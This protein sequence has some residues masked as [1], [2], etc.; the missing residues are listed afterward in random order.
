MLPTVLKDATG[1]PSRCDWQ[2]E[3]NSIDNNNVN[4]SLNLQNNRITIAKTSGFI[5]AMPEEHVIQGMPGTAATSILRLRPHIVI[6]NFEVDMPTTGYALLGLVSSVVMVRPSMWLASVAPKA[7]DEY[8]DV[9]KLNVI[10]NL[11][12]EAN[13]VGEPL[14]LKDTTL[15]PHEVYGLLKQMY[16]LDPV[17]SM[18]IEMCGANSNFLSVFAVAG[19]PSM[20]NEDADKKLNASKEIITTANW[21]T[22][23][24]F[25]LDFDPSKIFISPGI[26]VPT[27]TWTDKS[28]ESRDIKDID[29]SF[30]AGFGQSVELINKWALSN[31][32]HT[33]SGL[34]P[35]ITKID[36]ISK[37]IPNAEISGKAMRVTFSAEFLSTLS[38]ACATAG[39]ETR[40]D[41][42]VN[43]TEQSDIAVL[44]S[45]LNNAG[46]G[47]NTADFARA[48]NGG[49][50]YQ[51][52]FSLSGFNRF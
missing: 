3:L 24:A 14:D 30:I 49:A 21:L 31:V 20:T 34:D 43:Y 19:A 4:S 47:Q 26:L 50:N 36:I 5:D 32:P 33:V 1:K 12:N 6:N 22:N 17:C 28:G 29:L 45:Y 46:I 51:T 18:D 23:G 10:T 9:G 11:G 25:P 48:F 42:E 8:H 27:G 13:G 7:A 35:Y 15:K 16:S 52:P 38:A 2:I 41:P 40:Y 39:L 44:G 37:L